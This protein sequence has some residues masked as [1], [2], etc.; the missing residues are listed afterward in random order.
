MIPISVSYCP[1]SVLTEW[2]PNSMLDIIVIPDNAIS[3]CITSKA[4]VPRFPQHLPTYTIS[5]CLTLLFF[6]VDVSIR[7]PHWVLAV[8][9]CLTMALTA[10]ITPK[11]AVLGFVCRLPSSQVL[12]LMVANIDAWYSWDLVVQI[13]YHRKY[14]LVSGSYLSCTSHKYHIDGL[15]QDCTKDSNVLA[16]EIMQ[17]CT[18]PSMCSCSPHYIQ[19]TA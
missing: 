12:N 16:V 18:N 11:S 2:L 14:Y 15:V 17:A 13:K 6:N 10:C 5:V 9:L 4:V 1:V 19:L 3:V 7:I 8:N